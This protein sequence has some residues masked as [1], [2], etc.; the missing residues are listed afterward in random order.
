MITK[1][2][3]FVQIKKTEISDFLNQLQL[4]IPSQTAMFQLLVILS[5]LNLKLI[6]ETPCDKWDLQMTS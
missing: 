1:K 6:L 3:L 4:F 5:I 2:Q